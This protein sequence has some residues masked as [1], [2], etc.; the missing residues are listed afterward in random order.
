MN[1]KDYLIHNNINDYVSFKRSEMYSVYKDSFEKYFEECKYKNKKAVIH[2]IKRNCDLKCTCGSGLDV[3]WE[4]NNG[5][6]GNS[7]S[8]CKIKVD[9]SNGV[10]R[11]RM[12]ESTY[13]GEIY[14]LNETLERL[15]EIEDISI[16][17][18]S[19]KQRKFIKAYR[20]LYFSILKHT[21]NLNK[22]SGVCLRARIYS[23]NDPNKYR[24]K[25][26]ELVK[27]FDNV[28]LKFHPVCKDCEPKRDSIE[29]F[30]L[31]HPENWEER[32]KKNREE[33]RK[34]MKGIHSEEWYINKYGESIG[35]HMHK[36]HIDNMLSNQSRN[37]HSKISQKLFKSLVN[38]G[39]TDSE[40]AKHPK[41][42]MFY[43]SDEYSKKM[44]QKR[45]FV[46]FLHKD[47]VI[48]FQGNYW[49]KNTS[50]KDKLRK[51]FLESEGYKVLFIYEN[52]YKEDEIRELKKCINFLNDIPVQNRFLISTK[53][54]YSHF[55]NIANN[56]SKETLKFTF[57]DRTIEVSKKH[58]FFGP[59]GEIM[60]QDLVVGQ[61]V[62][63][64]NGLETIV[65]IETGENEVYDVIDSEDHTYYGNGVLNHNCNFLGSSSTLISAEKL[66]QMTSQECEEIRD[67]KLKI[68][69]YP[70]KGHQYIMT[71]DAAKDG[72]DFFAVQVVDITDFNFKQ[73]AA[74]Q[75]QIDYL[76]MPEFINE[77][78]EMYNN[79]YLIIEN[80]EGAGQSIADQMRN[81][82]EYENLHY[83]KDV[84]RNRKKKYPGFRTTPKTRKQILQ[85]LKLFIENDKL[86]VVDRATIQEF[87]QFILINNKYQA[88]EGAHDDMIMSLGL[89][90]VPFCNSRNFE[91]MKLLVK[92][93]YNDAELSE[94]EKVNFGEMMTIGSF[95]DG[96]D[97]EYLM[98]QGKKE[99]MSMEEFMEDQE[100]FF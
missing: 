66:S 55:M 18:G 22:M 51:E 10:K 98:E 40:F 45:I 14:S 30:K 100:G 74:A 76:L 96:T 15:G 78:A 6:F 13:D 64:K 71:V 43:L 11:S 72:T 92:N 35:K 86:E 84:G 53:S 48:E 57:D 20:K 67:G 2:Y 88:D 8:M 12:K 9:N 19:G 60:A 61:M 46:D 17:L 33:R 90:F 32:F 94:S 42:R 24:C 82:Y 50:E 89:V 56:G 44:G 95:D 73:V 85:T 5:H 77:W 91:D 83:D 29:W 41:E 70:V 31:Y 68:Y 81:D 75:L 62:E 87:F 93:L 99:Y 37:M 28:E 4:Q 39:F 80:N 58:K 21:E 65:N 36:R 16:Y 63:T 69:Q 38:E 7:C 47:K 79:P 23:L 49:H 3:Y 52:E 54:G 59:R 1:L 27:R 97:E 25:C 34:R 26:G